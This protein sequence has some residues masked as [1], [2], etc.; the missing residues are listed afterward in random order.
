VRGNKCYRNRRAGIGIRTGADTSPVVEDNECYGN[1]MAGIGCDMQCRPI[2]RNN[3]CYKNALAGIGC[4]DQAHPL[5]VGNQCYENHAAGIGSEREARPLIVQN[6]CYENAGAG[7]GQRGDAQT[8]L[9]GNH[10]HHNQTAGIGFEECKSGR[11]RVIDNRVLDNGQA[12]VG[13]HSGWKVR[14][15]GNELSRPDGMPP[16]V[17]VF[18]GAEAEFSD[19]I[20]RGSGVAGIRAE[21]TV[22]ATGNKFECPKPRDGDPPQFAFWGLPGSDI[23]FVGNTT[24]GWRQALFAEKSAVVVCDNR[25]ESY[26]SLAI[27]VNQ[28]SRT[29]VAVGNTFISQR[30]DVGVQVTGGNSVLENN[31]IT[32]PKPAS[33]LT[34]EPR[35][36]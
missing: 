6:E 21:G 33:R 20:I 32:S 30:D 9:V 4:Q 22:R 29:V 24:S 19:N 10:V 26:G 3:R 36:P 31:R 25:V 15:A 1:D 12:A 5:I 28:P 27:N 16:I 8:T 35:Q 34:E 13:I 18:Q 23:V 7:I 17:M 11:S 2:V 14:L